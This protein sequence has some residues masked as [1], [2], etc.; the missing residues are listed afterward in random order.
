[1]NL[2]LIRPRRQI[3]KVYKSH[4]IHMLTTE[5]QMMTLLMT[6][7]NIRTVVMMLWRN[8]FMVWKKRLP[9]SLQTSMIW[10][11]IPS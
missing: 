7:E 11:C 9:F 10:H 3:R 8:A 5:V 4:E 2:R 6:K 1:M